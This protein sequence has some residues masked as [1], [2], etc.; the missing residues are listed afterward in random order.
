MRS[1]R[2]S[3]LL[4]LTAIL[5]I[6]LS[7]A[8]T[9]AQ[10]P[11]APIGLLPL[12][13][14]RNV[15]QADPSVLYLAHTSSGVMRFTR[16]QVQ[17]PCENGRGGLSF[18]IRSLGQQPANVHAEGSVSGRVNYY[19]SSDRSTWIEGVALHHELDYSQIAQ[20]V[21]LVFHGEGG[22]LE[23]DLDVAAQA[24][25]EAISFAPDSG[26]SFS[27]ESDGSARFHTASASSCS[28]EGIRLLAPIAYQRRN[29]HDVP[30]QVTFRLHD[31]G[32]LGFSVSPYDHHLPLV[33]DPVVS[34]T[35]II[36]VNNSTT[37]NGMQA[38]SSGNVYIV[39]GTSA[40]NYPV[41][42]GQSGQG[43]GEEVY[44]T[45]L[46]ATGT[47]ILFSTYIPA[48]GFNSASAI[49][50]DPSGNVYV[51]GVTG[52]PSFPTTSQNLGTCSNFCNAGFAAKL[53]PTGTMVYST[54]LGSGQQ[55]P[56]SIVVDAAG[57]LYIAGL[58]A[59]AGLQTVNPFLS[60]YSGGVCT[61]CAGPFFAKLNAA[62]DA[63]VFS[64]YFSTAGSSGI[65]AFASGIALDTTGDVYIAGPGNTVP[66][67]NWFENGV[68]E[69]FV[70]EFSPD[71]Q[72]LLFSTL[73]GGN[74]SSQYDSL[75]PVQVGSDG[76]I[77]LAGSEYAPDFPFTINAFLLPVGQ[78]NFPRLFALAINPA[79]S[80]LTYSTSLGNGYANVTALDS[81][82]DF[83][84]G[85]SYN[86]ASLPFKNALADDSANSGFVAEFDPT[87]ALL[88]ATGFGGRNTTEPPTGLAL[89]GAGDIYIAGAPVNSAVSNATLDPINIGTGTSY[90][91]Q[92]ALGTSTSF[93]GYSTFIA[94][95]IPANQ[96]QI[97]LSYQNPFLELRDA[98][99]ADLHISSLQ[100]SSGFA[101]ANSTCGSTVPA[102]TSCFLTPASS[103]GA[104]ANG[105]ITINSD[106]VPASQSFTPSPVATPGAIGGNLI[107]DASQLNFPPQQTGTT[108]PA[109]PLTLTNTGTASLT[110]NSILT[111]GY[112]SQT[113]NCSVLAPQASCTAQITVSPTANGSSSA[114][115]GVVYNTGLRTDV[116]AYFTLNPTTSP[117][118]VSTPNIG[119][120]SLFTGQQSLPRE[121]TITNT[122]NSTTTVD[123][124]TITGPYASSF[125]IA[126]NACVGVSLQSQQSCALSIV[127]QAPANGAP[128]YATLNITDGAAAADT[129][130]LSGSIIT[131]PTVSIAPGTF[132]FGTLTV[133]QTAQ[134]VFQITNTGSANETLSDINILLGNSLAPSEYALQNTCT[135]ALSPANSCTVTITFTPGAI[136]T[137]NAVLSISINDGAAIQTLP[138]PANVVAPFSVSPSN[139]TFPSTLVGSSAAAQSI[140]ITNNLSTSISSPAFA[141]T[142]PN[143]ADFSQTSSCP[144]SLAGGANCAA[145]ITFKPSTSSVETA[146]L[147]LTSSADNTTQTVALSGTGL[148]PD[149]SITA[150]PTSMTITSGQVAT[151]DFSVTAPTGFAGNVN[152]SCSGLP[153][154]ATCSFSPASLAITGATTSTSVLSIATASQASLQHGTSIQF[155]V[156]FF[157]ALMVLVLPG[158]RR[159]LVAR[160]ACTLLFAAAG[161]LLVSAS[162][163]SG[164][165]S[166]PPPSEV[167][168]YTVT[169]TAVSG[170]QTHTTT[171]A[172]II[173]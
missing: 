27:L 66:L 100:V 65:E 48:S 38:D 77:Y 47:Q 167:G 161:L 168:T 34:Y 147:T 120:G 137:Y 111:F 18:N 33:I 139:L 121:V 110:V 152:L 101:S 13:F 138:I 55:L 56:K 84:I 76:T 119:F 144:A 142:G 23:Y 128:V 41:V 82:G 15:G 28:S 16:T 80:G 126:G 74:S 63:W 171:V 52:T 50:L 3:R 118:L 88:N 116:Y 140:T 53:S 57:E 166:A 151:Y 158:R 1:T 113:N 19:P 172:L 96:P 39:G 14:E 148:S 157:G 37:V 117:L 165:S 150:S 133:G 59:D 70:A 163:C 71:G 43:G 7:T 40:N 99:S 25:P 68:G 97:S 170:S 72:S 79:H 155:A 17:L 5:A 61:S 105:N 78:A 4:P 160:I 83:Y 103:T 6:A 2:V 112:F 20:G 141:I 108:S 62:G 134:Q 130:P 42:G 169:V 29:G 8:S 123:T 129:V 31:D 127:Y 54:L 145:S 73:L 94:K 87:G 173:Q 10:H 136:G 156:A 12:A 104:T 102:G 21:D 146:T 30:I 154:F 35:K 75:A 153:A 143:A 32:Q 124:P 114:D 109:R 159:R 122:S 93:I 46:N 49:A 22:R 90:S 125:I 89:D 106:A 132:S 58:T 98:G 60:T 51:A 149:F 115:I 107:V 95:I 11:A 44:V 164:G 131:Q 91:A 135:A 24:N 92:S 69:Y 45:K 9:Y 162:G 64:S 86:S 85:G 26:T 67:Q 81:K 36:G